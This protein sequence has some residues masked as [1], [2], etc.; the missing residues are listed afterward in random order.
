MNRDRQ[1]NQKSTITGWGF[2][3]AAAFRFFPYS[4]DII[5]DDVQIDV[6]VVGTRV[7]L[8]LLG[9]GPF[10]GVLLAVVDL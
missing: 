1:M 9:D 2:G 6:F 8:F 10:V 5:D 3:E 7:A 4:I